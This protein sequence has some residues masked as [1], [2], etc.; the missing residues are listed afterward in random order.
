[1]SNE[2]AQYDRKIASCLIA[3]Y[4]AAKNDYGFHRKDAKDAKK[5]R[6]KKTD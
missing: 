5:D 4:Y 2:P 3:G 6:G 1:M